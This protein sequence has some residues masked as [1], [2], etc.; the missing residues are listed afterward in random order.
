MS[1]VV[2]PVDLTVCRLFVQGDE[3]IWFATRCGLIGRFFHSYLL[4]RNRLRLVDRKIRGRKTQTNN[5]KPRRHTL[6]AAWSIN[7][8]LM[9]LRLPLRGNQFT[10]IISAYASPMT[11]S[12]AAKDE[13]YED[14][15]ALLATVPKMDKLIFLV[16]FITRVETDH[17]AWQGLLSES[18]DA[19]VDRKD[20]VSL[21]CHGYKRPVSAL[22]PIGHVGQDSEDTP[23]P[24]N[25]RSTPNSL[26]SLLVVAT[27]TLPSL[28][29]SSPLGIRS[30]CWTTTIKARG[31][32]L[33]IGELTRSISAEQLVSILQQ[34][35][36]QF[37]AVHLKMMECMLQQFSLHFPDPES[38][39]K[40]STSLAQ[41]LLASLNLFTADSGV[42]FDAW[43]KRWED[44]FRVEFANA[45][46]A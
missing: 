41:L 19:P 15:H 32:I 34:Q 20:S 40:Q 5:N 43:F 1:D 28:R 36:A 39:G 3:C 29:L 6:Q 21:S 37:E 16:D 44:I 35:Q 10:T 33:T 14:L 27:S 45:D 12:D 24:A 18:T 25:R 38:S 31:K 46:G 11:S 23:I 42:T 2:D 7:D 22:I 9:S 4:N 17:A 30:S 26:R 8:R 13:F